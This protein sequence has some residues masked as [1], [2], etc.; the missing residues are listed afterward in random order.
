MFQITKE[1]IWSCVLKNRQNN[2]QRKKDKIQQIIY[3]A[4]YKKLKI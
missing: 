3:E 1:V 4:R 2:D